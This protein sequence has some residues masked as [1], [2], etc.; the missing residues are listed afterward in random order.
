MTAG[1]LQLAGPPSQGLGGPARTLRSAAS[2]ELS[3]C[4]ERG[5]PVQPRDG[6]DRIVQPRD[7][8]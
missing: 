7:L 1:P 6:G 4:S 3:P 8:L 2:T 5:R